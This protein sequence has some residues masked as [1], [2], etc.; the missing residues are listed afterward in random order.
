[1]HLRWGWQA[2]ELTRYTCT[3]PSKSFSRFSAPGTPFSLT[4]LCITTCVFWS[5]GAQRPLDEGQE[6]D[7]HPIGLILGLSGWVFD[8]STSKVP[9]SPD[10]A[11][12]LQCGVL[13]RSA[14]FER[15]RSII[16]DRKVQIRLNLDFRLATKGRCS[17]NCERGSSL[18]AAALSC[19][20]PPTRC[21]SG[22]AGTAC[23]SCRL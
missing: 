2:P 10:V 20:P 18:F 5:G 14:S 21:D 23:R 17:Q 7:I 3:F 19:V 8:V 9:F 12:W 11:G 15:S 22:L 6:G 13:G 4:P 16:S 1:M